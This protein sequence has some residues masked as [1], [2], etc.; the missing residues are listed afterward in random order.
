MQL[1]TREP[2]WMPA[3]SFVS[4][5]LPVCAGSKSKRKARL[6]CRLTLTGRG[7]RLPGGPGS[8]CAR[9]T[10]RQ[11]VW[12][13][14]H[15]TDTPCCAA[16]GDAGGHTH[17]P[18]TAARGGGRGAGAVA[19]GMLQLDAPNLVCGILLLTQLYVSATVHL[20]PSALVPQCTGP[21]QQLRS[22]GGNLK[23][24]SASSC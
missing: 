16:Q 23:H 10:G 24:T 11:H 3:R 7:P 17:R 21:P 6:L 12:R 13:L 20:S 22:S 15:H 2:S 19:L 14:R 1:S 5:V 8:L 4:A 18:P 9:N